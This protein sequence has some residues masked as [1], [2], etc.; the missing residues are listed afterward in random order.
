M[1]ILMTAQ[2]Y[3]PF[4]DKGG[5]AVKVRAIALGLAKLGHSVAV[6][7]SDWGF[8]PSM[9]PTMSAGKCRLGWCA[10]EFGVTTFFLRSVGCYRSLSLNPDVL[11]FSSRRI[12]GYDVVHVYGLY[13]F[14]GP[15]VTF[16]CRS[17]H[18]PYVVE[19]MGMFRPIV[20]NIGMKKLYHRMLGKKLLG[21]AHCLI[22]TSDQ[23]KGELVAEGIDPSRIIVRRNGV[24]LPPF[25]PERGAFRAQWSIPPHV[26]LVLFLGRLEAKKSPELLLTAFAE[27]RRK[28]KAA[29]PSFLAIAGPE[30][31]RG[32]S[33]RLTSM[34]SSLGI[35]DS[36]RLTGPLYDEKKWSAYRDADVFVLPSQNENFGNSAAEAMAGGTPV[37]VTDQCGIAPLIADRTGL[38]VAHDASAIANALQLILE[39]PIVASRF[40][41]ACPSVVSGLSWEEPISQML[42]VYRA[43]LPKGAVT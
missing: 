34:A 30:Q 28:S 21:S 41:S 36:V 32:Y 22:A 12:R 20:R 38:V 4:C 26:K 35:A 33:S 10:Q 2:A 11:T 16:F 15:A 14:L 42:S 19:P 17:N 25:L 24:E 1:N 18:I 39:D 27:W 29:A 3:Y 13:D 5:P 43:A 40:R 9:A 6:L 8:Q 37:I 23:E 31:Q 7:T